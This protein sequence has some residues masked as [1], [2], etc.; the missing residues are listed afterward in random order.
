MSKQ[1]GFFY[2]V[3]RCV[4]CRTCEV[5][6]KSFRNV[7]PGL[8]WRRVVETWSGEF[9]NITRTFLSLACMH[10]VKPACAAVCPTG[11]II[12]R[13]E[14]GIVVVDR[15]K[16]NGCQECFY[17]C[18]FG[19]P[20]FGHDGIMQKCD[21]C[22]ESGGEP[23]CA[24]SCPAEA[25]HYGTMEGLA[26]L[27]TGKSAERLTGPTEPSIFITNKLGANMIQNMF[28]KQ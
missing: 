6:C 7:E 17:A 27:A 8:K 25:I 28:A 5:A 16:C 19:I 11:A 23:A 1:Y 12:K 10:C 26:E 18:P 4:Q 24:A 15:D 13:A 9:P 2:D 14:D 3:S 22:I 21:F 20:Q